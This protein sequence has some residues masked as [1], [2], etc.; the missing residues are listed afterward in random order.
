M[1]NVKV[2]IVDDS[3]LIRSH[4][5]KTL[6]GMRGVEIVG[7]APDPFVAREILLKTSPDLVLL[8]IE[9][10][11]MDGLT[12]L[13]KIMRY[14]PTPTLVISSVTPKGSDTA[15]ACLESGAIDVLCKPSSAYSIEDLQ[16]QIERWIR[17]VATQG[18][19]R[20][21]QRKAALAKIPEELPGGSKIA[22][23]NRLVA[24]GSSAGGPETLKYVLSALP[25]SAPGIAIVQ[26]MGAAFLAQMAQRLD[27]ECR[28]E[29]KLAQ[30]GDAVIP[31]RALLAPGDVHMK[32]VRRGARYEVKLE[33]GSPVA[34]HRPAV[35]VMFN[36]V[37]SA[38]GA[39]AMAV[40]LTGMGHDGADG[41]KA[42]KKA[43]ARCVAQDEETSIVFGMPARA[44]DTG[45]VDDILPLPLVPKKI[46]DF[47]AQT[48]V[49]RAG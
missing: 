8:D 42:M 43:G 7:L 23:T 6:S 17:E 25:R 13:R 15:L 33:N 1:S 4:L 38:A 3:A 36:S 18:S 19:Q 29:V 20:L 35:D 47:G 2:L 21:A 31:G 34:G 37:A 32:I 5:K 44:I 14:K 9:M 10:P 40:V 22:T 45:C 28:I 41:I 12:F 30:N 16:G 26:H 11:R 49:Q 27:R 39:N 46:L 48:S 24:I